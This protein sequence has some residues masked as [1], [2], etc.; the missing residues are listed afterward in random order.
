MPKD[1]RRL[2]GV[3]E[4]Q[5]VDVAALV[6]ARAG[7]LA[8]THAEEDPLGKRRAVRAEVLEVAALSHPQ[9]GGLAENAGEGVRGAPGHV[10]RGDA[11]EGGAAKDAPAAVGGAG[12]ARRGARGGAGIRS[13]YKTLSLRV[14]GRVAPERARV[15]AQQQA[16]T[17]RRRLTHGIMTIQHDANHIPPA[18]AAQ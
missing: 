5:L 3:V 14:A 10:E 7:V 2:A 15:H 9:R 1:V 8:G 18:P 6:V 13:L 11:A 4:Q 17:P 12:V 16:Q